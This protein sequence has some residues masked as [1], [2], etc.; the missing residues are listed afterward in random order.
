[1]W[2]DKEL[3][4]PLQLNSII[5]MIDCFN[6]F[7]NYDLNEEIL[8]K[9]IICADKIIL[10]KIDLLNGLPDADQ[11]TKIK[12]FILKTNPLSK[13]YEYDNFNY[14]GLLLLI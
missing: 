3:E 8:K 14:K 4:S 10:N 11:K 2:L 5:C 13:I 6:F 7:K 9:Q 1:M 12:E